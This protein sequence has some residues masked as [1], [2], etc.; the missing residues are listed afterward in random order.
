MTLSFSLGGCSGGGGGGEGGEKEGVEQKDPGQHQLSM[1][2]PPSTLNHQTPGG[3][4]PAAA[5]HAEQGTPVVLGVLAGVLVRGSPAP[6]TLCRPRMASCAR[7]P[8]DQ[9]TE[10][11][12]LSAAT[13]GTAQLGELRGKSTTH[14]THTLRHTAASPVSRWGRDATRSALLPC[15]PRTAPH[16][17]SSVALGS[18]Q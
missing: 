11:V 3:G 13:P 2:M 6:H 8:A 18:H 10:A 9:T 4:P 12:R 7:T 17:P 15:Q 14:Q 16:R 1:Y 5:G